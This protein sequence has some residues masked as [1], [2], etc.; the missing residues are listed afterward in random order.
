MAVSVIQHVLKYKVNLW[1]LSI[2][3]KWNT[4]FTYFIIIFSLVVTFISTTNSS[5]REFCLKKSVL[6]FIFCLFVTAFLLLLIVLIQ[7]ES[8]SNLKFNKIFYVFF[9]GFWDEDRFP[10][11]P[12]ISEGHPINKTAIVN[13]NATFRCPVVTDIAA[14]ITWARYHALDKNDTDFTSKQNTVKLEVYCLIIISNW[15]WGFFSFYKG[16]IVGYYGVSRFSL[17]FLNVY[18]SLVSLMISTQFV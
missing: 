9:C 5:G 4:L 18:L 2:N 8:N 1:I 17:S 12:Y 14:H 11:A 7:I 15:W 10:S 6:S 13:G 16:W 3:I